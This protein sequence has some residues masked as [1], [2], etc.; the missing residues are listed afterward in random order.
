MTLLKQ[1]VKVGVLLVKADKSA[2]DAAGSAVDA[3]KDAATGAVDAAKDAA[4]S[5]TDKVKDAVK[6]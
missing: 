4:G 3:T 6:H 5:A 2:K 1:K